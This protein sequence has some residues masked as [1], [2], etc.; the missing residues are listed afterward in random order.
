MSQQVAL[1]QKQTFEALAPIWSELLDLPSEEIS[2]DTDFFGAGGHSLTA[3]LAVTQI[4]KKI[5]KKVPLFALVENPTL[6]K[7]SGFVANL[8]NQERVEEAQAP[9]GSSSQSERLLGYNSPERRETR[10]TF[11]ENYYAQAM[12]SEAHA[13]FCRNVYGD[14]FGQHGMADKEQLDLLIQRLAIKKGDIV[15]DMGCGYGLISKYIAEA[16]GAK[17][18]GVDLSAS[19]IKFAKSMALGNEGLEFHEMDIA[20]LEFAAGT[21]SHIISIDTIYY[22]PSLPDLLQCFRKIGQPDVKL[23]IIRTYPKRTFTKQT[24]SPDRTQLASELKEVFDGYETF[25]LSREENEHWRQKKEVLESLEQQFS[26]EGSRELWEFRYKEAAYEAG[27][28]Q[29]RYMFVTGQST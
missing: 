26:D 11:F 20:K 22:A 16:T 27:I 10:N 7:F 14:N 21:F 24:W 2:E 18:I 8:D 29:F 17:V 9:D 19:A 12:Q 4:E 6:A 28:E 15:L 25:D 23:G 13:E 1:D 3:M 5:G